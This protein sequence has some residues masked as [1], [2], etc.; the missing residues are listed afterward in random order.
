MN[1]FSL[2]FG[3]VVEAIKTLGALWLEKKKAR[4]EGEIA[5][6]K[7]VA[8]GQIDYNVAAQYASQTSWKD[9]WLTIWTTSVVTACFIPGLQEYIITGF[10][11][12]GSLPAWFT[13]CFIGMYVAVF[14]LK[15][16][17]EFKN[18]K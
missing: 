8:A 4:V 17:K 10:A 6:N 5:I 12:L 2:V 13:Y 1:P 18:G 15:G 16:W 9:E 3:G 7:A 14:G 11:A